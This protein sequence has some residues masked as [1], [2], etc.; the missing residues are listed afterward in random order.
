MDPGTCKTLLQPFHSFPCCLHGSFKDRWFWQQGTTS[1]RLSRYQS[2][3]GLELAPV[4]PP[5]SG[6]SVSQGATGTPH[7]SGTLQAEELGCCGHELHVHCPWERVRALHK[8]AVA[9][10]LG[11]A[12]WPQHTL[13]SARVLHT[14][15]VQ[16]LTA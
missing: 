10:P 4:K 1:H 2:A 8:K 13:R 7:A 6:G 9:V 11:N 12:C 16:L 5:S 15:C 3:L 14:A